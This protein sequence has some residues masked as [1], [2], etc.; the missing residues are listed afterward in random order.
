MAD[1]LRDSTKQTYQHQWSVYRRWCKKTQVT[2]SRPSLQKIASFLTYLHEERKL[3]PSAIKCYRSMLSSVFHWTLPELSSSRAIRDLL[4]GV[5]NRSIRA[6]R[7][8]PTWDLLRTLKALKEPP[9]EPLKLADNRSLLKKTLFLVA[10]ATA[11]R[12]GELQAI[13]ATVASST[14]G[15]EL[16]YLPEFVAKTETANNPIPRSFSLT[17]LK[18]PQALDPDHRLLCPVRALKIYLKRME[19]IEHRPRQLFVA[20]KD[21]SR[22]ASKNAISFFL[23]E[24]IAQ[25]NAFS[26]DQCEAHDV[27]GVSS[28]FSFWKNW[29]TTKILESTRWR[30]NNVFV[31]HYLKDVSYRLNDI[32]SLGP[33]VTAGRVI[34]D[35][36]L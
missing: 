31:N 6:R 36:S 12:V 32:G 27:R 17:K 22:P 10:L 29:S 15:L 11:K 8:A 19:S 30:S 21:R 16:A 20:L 5:Q 9:Y 23:R 18:D 2:V 34:H 33:F 26:S 4:R 35:S 3:S 13:S 25:A 14:E 28:S 7:T 1:S 24:T